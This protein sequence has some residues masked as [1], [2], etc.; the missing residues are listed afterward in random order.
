MSRHRAI[1]RPNVSHS[2]HSDTIVHS[3]TH[4]EIECGSI[5]LRFVSPW[6]FD[7]NRAE[8]RL[9]EVLDVLEHVAFPFDG[10]NEVHADVVLDDIC[11]TAVGME[12]GQCVL[13]GEKSSSYLCP[14]PGI[15]IVEIRVFDVN[16]ARKFLDAAVSA[17][18]SYYI[19]VLDFVTPSTMLQWTDPDVDCCNPASWSTLFC[20]QF[21]L[22][23]L[24]YLYM[25]GV[26]CVPG[27]PPDARRR[28]SALF[29]CSS[30]VCSPAHL[31]EILHTVLGN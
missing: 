21:V 13:K 11:Y 23:F 29:Q 18:I 24:R 8:Q 17:S 30:H 10:G 6:Y 25:H 14:H 2:R 19:P 1:T 26:L 20:S 15:E 27:P 9:E 31:R 16:F 5:F 4:P 3:T 22:L 28:G 7:D 12:P